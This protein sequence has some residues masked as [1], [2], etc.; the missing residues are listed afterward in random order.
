MPTRVVA[1]SLF[2]VRYNRRAS[3]PVPTDRSRLPVLTFLH[4]RTNFRLSASG[5]CIRSL[6]LP[7]ATSTAVH[8]ALRL[9][10][11]YTLLVAYDGSS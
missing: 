2:L 1:H 3:D 11:T 6:S 8:T 5:A 7:G 9:L 10:C 4:P